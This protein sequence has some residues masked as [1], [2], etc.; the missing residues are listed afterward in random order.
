MAF[1]TFTVGEVLEAAEVN[2]YLMKQSVIVCTSGTRP[3]SPVEGMTIY[4]TD[5]NAVR[6]HDGTDWFQVIHVGA[7]TAFTPTWTGAS[8][9]PAIG[10]G[11]LQ[12]A[13][14]QTG[15]IMNF[16]M[17]M[18]AGSTTTF[19]SGAW[20]FA[21]PSAFPVLGNTCASAFAEDSSTSNRYGGAAWLEPS[22]DTVYRI[23]LGSGGNV[24]VSSTVPFTWATG[25]VLLITGAY[26][27]DI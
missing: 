20:S 19:G 26:E 7:W 9:N 18:I 10:N 14:K 2:D 3:S 1:K 25:D 5:T 17:S 15:R 27:T 8:S 23:A 6:I 12:G 13:Y 16:R 21:L 22:V 24:G 11:S 4:E